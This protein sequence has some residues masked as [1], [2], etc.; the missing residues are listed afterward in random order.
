MSLDNNVNQFEFNR[1]FIFQLCFSLLFLNLQ[2]GVVS[3]ESI[4]LFYINIKEKL[5]TKKNIHKNRKRKS[6]QKEID[7]KRKC[8]RNKNVCDKLKRIIYPFMNKDPEM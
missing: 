6:K 8:C 4:Y 2:G 1:I 3:I 5:K 7:S